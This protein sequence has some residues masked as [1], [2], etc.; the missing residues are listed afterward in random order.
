MLRIDLDGIDDAH[1]VHHPSMKVKTGYRS[2]RTV[3][4]CEVMDT[5]DTAA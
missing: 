2:V 5:I 4:H 3:Q 1:G